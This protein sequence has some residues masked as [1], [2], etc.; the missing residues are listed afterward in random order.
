M[1]NIHL[2]PSPFLNES[3]ILREARL[4]EKLGLFERID[5][6]GTGR[7][8]L[9]VTEA[10]SDRIHI[11]RIGLRDESLSFLEK[12]QATMTWSAAVFRSY[13]GERIGCVNCHSI[14]TL[15]LGVRFK[16]TTGARLVYDAHELETETN[17][18]HGLRKRLTKL[19]ER[20][21]I[22]QADHCIFVGDAIDNW[23]REAYGITNTTVL[24]NCPPY[25]ELQPSDVFR[26]RFGIPADMPIFLYQGLIGE[27]RG[28]RLLVE[29]FAGLRG[30]AA[31]VILGYGPLS[32]WVREQ[33]DACD[34]VFHH[35]AVPPGELLSYTAAADVGLSVIE[36]TSLSYEYCMPNKLFEYIMA[37]KPLIVS[38]TTEQRSFLRRFRV[39]EVASELT[40]D[41]LRSAVMTLLSRPPGHYQA[42]LARARQLFNW[43]RQEKALE[44]V[45]RQWLGF[46]APVRSLAPMEGE[47]T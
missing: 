27:G 29:A 19:T 1:I 20:A 33:A 46:D 21:L 22:G 14:A 36:P 38:P 5:L 17:G 15:P 24:Y 10:V 25:R 44:S 18:L 4:L 40:A 26:E 23:Y 13:R 7:S 31:L 34:N 6:V 32:G 9:A 8:D 45:Y 2:Y 39:G 37:G 12:T 16:R 43:D 11:R 47:A 35:P 41:A 3:R 30:R 28:L 42:E